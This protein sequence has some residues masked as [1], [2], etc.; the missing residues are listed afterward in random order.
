MICVIDQIKYDTDK[1]EMVSDKIQHE[2]KVR[3]LSHS[4]WWDG[5]TCSFMEKSQ[6]KM[7]YI[8]YGNY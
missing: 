7:A 2:Y 8:Q 3:I 5:K 4:Y 6:R 1:M